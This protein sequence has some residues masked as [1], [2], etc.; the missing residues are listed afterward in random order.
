LNYEKLAE[1]IEKH[2]YTLAQSVAE[3]VIAQGLP[4]YSEIELETLTQSFLPNIEAVAQ[5]IRDGNMETLFQFAAE[6]G[7]NSMK[8]GAPMEAVQRMDKIGFEHVRLLVESEF[9]GPENEAARQSFYNRISALTALSQ[10]AAVVS[11]LRRS[12]P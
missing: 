6:K 11:R 10:T 2:K 4:V 3:E 5:Y 9:P 12:N 8:K 1:I 7:R